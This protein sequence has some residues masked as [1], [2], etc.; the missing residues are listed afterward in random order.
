TS[1]K[2]PYLSRPWRREALV[3]Q[4][5][6]TVGT[7]EASRPSMRIVNCNTGVMLALK[8]QPSFARGI[9]QRLDSSV[10][11]KTAAVEHHAVHTCG[12][13][14][15]GDRL[16]DLGRLRHAVALRFDLDRRSSREGAAGAIVD[17]LVVQVVQAA[18]HR[19]PRP[20]GRARDVHPHALVPLE[21]VHLAVL[22]LDHAVVLAPLPALPGLRRTFSPRYIT[23]L[24]L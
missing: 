14:L 7:A 21:P 11:E 1:V 13:R 5:D 4:A 15:G 8:L 18:K 19:Q 23:P 2:A 9:G 22:S 20:L 24:P 10:I 6:S 12:L 16:A 3:S 17:E